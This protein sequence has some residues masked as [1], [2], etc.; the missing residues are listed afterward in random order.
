[1][2][3]KDSADVAE[4]NAKRRRGSIRYRRHVSILRRTSAVDK[5]RL[6]IP[7]TC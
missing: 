3:S 7:M 5:R 1:M 2:S 4:T 6:A